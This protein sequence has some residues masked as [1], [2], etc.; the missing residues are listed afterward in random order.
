MSDSAKM[1]KVETENDAKKLALRV[2]TLEMQL[3]QSVPKKEHHEVTSKLERQIDSLEK[4]LERTRE[5]GAKTA[6][7]NKQIEGVEDLI[8]SLIKTS[9]GHGKVLESIEDDGAA[10]G[11]ALNAQGKVID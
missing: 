6:A 11:K 4:E 3:R 5:A 9:A 10:R 2:K 8:S 1:G 7:I